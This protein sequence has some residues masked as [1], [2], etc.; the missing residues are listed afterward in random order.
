MLLLVRHLHRHQISITFMDTKFP[1]PFH[2]PPG[3]PPSWT[4][5]MLLLVRHQISQTRLLQATIC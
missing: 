3:A 5:H 1:S 4:Q 2:A